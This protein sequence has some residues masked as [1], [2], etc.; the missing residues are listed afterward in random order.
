MHLTDTIP[1]KD[2][3]E[4]SS[5][6]PHLKSVDWSLPVAIAV[7]GGGDSMALLASVLLLRDRK[8]LTA[9]LHILTVDHGLRSD[10]ADEATFVA[11]FCAQFGIDHTVLNW[12]GVKPSSAV[13]ERARMMRRDLLLS[14]CKALS[15]QQLLL[16]HTLDDVA[17]TL[18]MR[19]RRGGLRGHAA[20]APETQFSGLRLLRPFLTLRRDELRAGLR[21]SG[22]FWCDDPTNENIQYE[23]PRM[24]RNLRDMERGDCPTDKIATYATLMGR[25]RVVMAWQIADV[26]DAGCNL[27]GTDVHISAEP[28]RH[29]PHII[30]VETLR[31]L[32]RFVG[33]DAYMIDFAQAKEAI[34]KIVNEGRAGKAFSSGRCVLS[35]GKDGCWTISRARRDLPVTSVEAGGTVSWDGRFVVQLGLAAQSSGEISPGIVDGVQGAPN[36]QP[37]GL[38]HTITFRPR[39]LDG[40]IASFDEPIFRA[41]EALLVR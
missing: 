31:E 21:R 5:F 30:A 22:I 7:S 14:E 25:W 11:G 35:P 24:R 6:L 4:L 20:I 19:V 8:T 3:S 2:F 38:S 9:P 37:K 33:G 16:G 41:L 23:R 40:P 26:I 32:V 34:R 18:L 15:V 27:L 10:S 29:I 36:V 17:E 12:N 28:L 39:V 1:D 13:A